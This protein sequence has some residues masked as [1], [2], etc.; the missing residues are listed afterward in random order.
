MGEEAVDSAEGYLDATVTSAAPNQGNSF[1]F[2]NA[3][4]DVDAF[5][6]TGGR[7]FDD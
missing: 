5:D 4:G 3:H 2:A 1:G 7:G 6:N